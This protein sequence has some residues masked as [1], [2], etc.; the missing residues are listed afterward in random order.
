MHHAL[1]PRR[2]LELRAL[3]IRILWIHELRDN[4]TAALQTLAVVRDLEQES[5]RVAGERGIA[6]L[7]RDVALRVPLGL[8]QRVELVVLDVD[9]EL[10]AYFGVFLDS[11]EHLG[12]DYRRNQFFS[13]SDFPDVVSS[14]QLS[15]RA[16]RGAVATTHLRTVA[17]PWYG[18]QG[19][20]EVT[21]TTVYLSRA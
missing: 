6:L 1:E 12:Y 2:C 21:L 7:I 4:A 10:A 11:D 19:D 17:N 15:Q 3:R 13:P 16:G 9:D 18:V 20:M 8:E 5:V 14:L